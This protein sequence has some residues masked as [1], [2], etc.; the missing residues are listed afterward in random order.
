MS[1]FQISYNFP[2]TDMWYPGFS[3]ILYFSFI[4]HIIS[5]FQIPYHLL[6]FKNIIMSLFQISHHFPV[7]WLCYVSLSDIILCHCFRYNIMFLFQISYYAFV[8]DIITYPCFSEYVIS[9]IFRYRIMSVFQISCFCFG[10]HT[11]IILCL[12]QIS[13]YLSYLHICRYHI[14]LQFRVLDIILTPC[15]RYY[16]TPFSQVSLYVSVLDISNVSGG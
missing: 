3:F 16:I 8:S 11:D 4:Y 14:I 9:F 15:F 13:Y 6:V 7:W 5:L 12:L 10:F 1:R 2:V